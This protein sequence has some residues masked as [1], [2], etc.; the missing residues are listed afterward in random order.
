[1]EGIETLSTN[2]KN[3]CSNG[4]DLL[5]GN[6]NIVKTLNGLQKNVG[7][8]MEQKTQ[9]ERENNPAPCVAPF[10]TQVLRGTVLP[11]QGAIKCCLYLDA[12]KKKTQKTEHFT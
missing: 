5:Y 10:V 1:M 2:T 4:K 11:L 9:T 7:E 3:Q 6:F 12:K 8:K